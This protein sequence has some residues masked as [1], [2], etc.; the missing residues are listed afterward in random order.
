MSNI[1]NEQRRRRC[2][3]T[4]TVG[5]LL[6]CVSLIAPFISQGSDL[7]PYFKWIYA[8]GALVYTV[9]RVFGV[10][11]PGISLRM[12]R[13]LRLQFWGGM[14]FVVGAALWFYYIQHLG[15]YAGM[16]AVMRNTV[17]FTLA[18]AVVQIISSWMIASQAKKEG[19]DARI[20]RARQ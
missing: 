5:L 13:L 6:V 12:K 1:T 4:A 20:G 10:N 2:E 8:L 11:T 3:G 19:G 16:L 7:Q 15:P 17:V 14:C 18:G 9:A